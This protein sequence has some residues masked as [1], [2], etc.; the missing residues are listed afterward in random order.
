MDSW[1]W[2]GGEGYIRTGG[3]GGG[4]REGERR[5]WLCGVRRHEWVI[6]YLKWAE[7]MCGYKEKLRAAVFEGVGKRSLLSLMV[8]FLFSCLFFIHG[9]GINYN[10]V[11]CAIPHEKLILSLSLTLALLCCGHQFM[12]NEHCKAH[13]H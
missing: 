12:I 6:I 5:V 1:W 9:I 11:Y 13:S 7:C 8:R 3:R 2:R 10:K 4:R